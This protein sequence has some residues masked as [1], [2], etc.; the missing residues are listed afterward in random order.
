MEPSNV[1]ALP[2]LTPAMY[3]AAAYVF[4]AFLHW[5]SGKGLPLLKELGNWWSG[6]KREIREDAKEGPERELKVVLAN[7]DE[8][9]LTVKGMAVEL[10]ELRKHNHNCEVSMARADE[11]IKVLEEKV[12]ERDKTIA[13][14]QQ[15]ILQLEEQVKLQGQMWER[16]EVDVAAVKEG[17]QQK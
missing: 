13:A 6:N 5:A 1:P 9:K 4:M 16:V 8:L 15:R 2:E 11:K 10:A 7:Y 3:G 12:V 14:Q 17:Q